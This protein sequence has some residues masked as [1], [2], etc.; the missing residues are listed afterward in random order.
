MAQLVLECLLAIAVVETI[1]HEH[2]VIFASLWSL[3]N[4]LEDLSVAVGEIGTSIAIMSIDVIN[5]GAL[6]GSGHV[7]DGIVI[8]ICMNLFEVVAFWLCLV[9]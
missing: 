8:P 5:E 2:D 3:L 1:S 7:D 9:C 4:D 6:L